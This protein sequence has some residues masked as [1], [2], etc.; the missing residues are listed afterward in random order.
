MCAA[1]APHKIVLPGI[2]GKNE[3]L[4]LNDAVRRAPK[5]KTNWRI[6]CSS[7]VTPRRNSGF[8][9]TYAA[10]GTLETA[11]RAR[12]KAAP[13]TFFGAGTASSLSF[14]GD[15]GPEFSPL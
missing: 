15:R 10:Y 2:F 3:A 12:P 1:E 5:R 14:F 4:P 13:R 9:H 11:P 7:A 8:F 6:C